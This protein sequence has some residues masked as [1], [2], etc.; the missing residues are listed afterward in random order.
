MSKFENFG[1]AT[2]LGRAERATVLGVII[3]FFYV[4]GIIIF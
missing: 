4:Y 2:A 1:V 3:F